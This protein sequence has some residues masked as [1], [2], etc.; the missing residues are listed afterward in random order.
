MRPQH[1]ATLLS[2]FGDAAAVE[3]AAVAGDHGPPPGGLTAAGY[4]SLLA[5]IRRCDPAG[6]L[7]RLRRMGG[8]IIA[9]T[10]AR[11]PPQ[12]MQIPDP[13]AALRVAG[14]VEILASVGV[15]VV[16]TRRCSDAGTRQAGRFAGSLAAS[17]VTIVSG[18]ARGIDA[19]A[20]RASVRAQGRTVVVLGSGLG[21]PYPSEHG[22]L[23][24]TIRQSGGAIVS[25]Y[26]MDRAPRPGQ[27]P[28]R[29]RLISGLSV[30]VLIV[31]AP[32]RSGAMLTARLAVEAHG[33]EC[34]AVPADACR[35]EARGGLEAIRDGWA[36]CAI[37]PA[38]VLADVVSP[39]QATKDA[40]QMLQV[41]EPL[42]YEVVQAL[43]RGGCAIG[44]LID[45]LHKPIGGV[46]QAVTSLELSGVLKRTGEQ[47]ALTPAGLQ[48]A[49][50]S[51][52]GRCPQ[53]S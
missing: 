19:E 21:R 15:A 42:E 33:R 1:A 47:I 51:R 48:V 7:E 40:P 8:D 36:A 14:Q 53:P 37:D 26:P 49:A 6:E 16:G 20:H 28:R 22:T 45:G 18:G 4:A 11:F 10:D 17:G 2:H 25:E 52:R 38:D 23:F 24:D 46:M 39:S 27:F 9:Y 5:A 31:E 13:P 29:N 35:R 12:L 30:G 41:L 34:W 43:R 50:A 32:V 3:A 44:A